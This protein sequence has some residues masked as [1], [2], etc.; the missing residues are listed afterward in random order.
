M[1]DVVIYAKRRW[2][3]DKIVK[4][5]GKK[6]KINNMRINCSKIQYALKEVKLLGVTVNGKKQ[7]PSKIKRNEALE[8]PRPTCIKELRKFLGLTG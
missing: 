5:I 4:E 6:L 2:E 3:H 1:D 7:T 8:Y